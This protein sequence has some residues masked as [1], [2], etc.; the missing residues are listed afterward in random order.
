MNDHDFT[1]LQALSL[2]SYDNGT[3]FTD[4]SRLEMII[5][6]SQNTPYTTCME[7]SRFLLFAKKP[8]H[9]LPQKLVVISS[10]IDAVE[11]ITSFF[12]KRVDNETLCGTFD[13]TLTNAAAVSLMQEGTLPENVVFAFTANEEQDGLGARDV[14]SY[15]KNFEKEFFAIVLDVTNIGYGKVHHTI[16]NDFWKSA[17]S[18]AVVRSVLAKTQLPYRFVCS[19]AAAPY[20][21]PIS[22]IELNSDGG[23]YEALCDESWTYHENGIECFSLCIPTMG[24][25]HTNSGI[26]CEAKSFPSYKSFVASFALA[27]AAQ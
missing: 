11:D 8:L 3:V 26:L 6:L 17:S 2:P 22:Y 10:H 16:E 1:L 5:K 21:I 24:E 20:Y 18:D 9:D 7:E 27:L 12:A 15:L 25:M 4:R 19:K 14:V 23:V 13:N